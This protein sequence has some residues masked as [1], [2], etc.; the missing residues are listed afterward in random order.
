MT[1]SYHDMWPLYGQG[2]DGCLQFRSRPPLTKHKTNDKKKVNYLKS[3]AFPSSSKQNST[4]KP[5]SEDLLLKEESTTHTQKNT[6]GS[7]STMSSSSVTSINHMG[8]FRVRSPQKKTQ[9][10]FEQEKRKMI[11]SLAVFCGSLLDPQ[12]LHNLNGRIFF[13]SRPKHFKLSHWILGRSVAQGDA[14]YVPYV[15]LD[16]FF[17]IHKQI[18]WIK[19]DI[20]CI[21]ND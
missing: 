8:T 1:S 19:L 16:F 15:F 14:D 11:K 20:E 5:N 4:N 3:M 7:L 12:H 21:Y 9:K 2:G 13:L 18:S 6:K 17:E 10:N